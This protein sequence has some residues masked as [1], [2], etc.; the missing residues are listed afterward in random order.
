MKHLTVCAPL[1]SFSAAMFLAGAAHATDY[2]VCTTNSNA[3]YKYYH[4]AIVE[5]ESSQIARDAF[6]NG[7]FGRGFEQYVAEKYGE[8]GNRDTR[9]YIRDSIYQTER[10]QEFTNDYEKVTN[11]KTGWTDGRPVA[12]SRSNERRNVEGVAIGVAGASN[13]DTR[14][15]NSS[16]A[17]ANTARDMATAEANINANAATQARFEAQLAENDR[18]LREYAAENARITARYE[19]AVRASEEEYRAV[20][21]DWR[22]R[23]AACKAG[24]VTQCA[25]ARPN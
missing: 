8:D 1:L 9:C 5:I 14:P 12:V 25:T 15:I 21:A 11:I 17:N 22:R 6:D 4:S 7:N 13:T 10:L 3:G 19:A 23:V 24:D 20:Q 16:I 18:A 2:A